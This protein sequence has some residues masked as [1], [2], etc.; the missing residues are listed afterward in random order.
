MPAEDFQAMSA[1]CIAVSRN[2]LDFDKQ[3][4]EAYEWLELRS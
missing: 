1:C 3:M 2:E 4:K